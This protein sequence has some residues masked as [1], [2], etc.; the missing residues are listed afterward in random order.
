MKITLP[1]PSK[2][3]SPNARTHW[4][5]KLGTNLKR[6]TQTLQYERVISIKNTTGVL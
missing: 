4:S 6:P 2:E 1:W 5:K 3:L